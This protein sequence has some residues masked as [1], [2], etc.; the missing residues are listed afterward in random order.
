MNVPGPIKAANDT[1]TTIFITYYN[2][3]LKRIA[4]ELC[5]WGIMLHAGLSKKIKP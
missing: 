4:L 2:K 5:L 3:N 1:D